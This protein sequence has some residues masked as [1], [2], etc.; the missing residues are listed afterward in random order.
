M[1]RPPAKYGTGVVWGVL[2]CT[3]DPLVEFALTL[4]YGI[5]IASC[6]SVPEPAAQLLI[7]TINKSC[8]KDPHPSSINMYRSPCLL[9][10]GLWLN[11]FQL[12]TNARHKSYV[13]DPRSSPINTY[14][15]YCLL[16]IGLWLNPFQLSLTRDTNCIFWTHIA[17]PSIHTD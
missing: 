13:T 6:W 8:V 7:D 9:I 15:S 17:L 2:L 10:I 14:R 3:P 4:L 16:V 5:T 1:S 12:L 11:L